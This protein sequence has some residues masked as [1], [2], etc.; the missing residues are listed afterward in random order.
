MFLWNNQ[1][2]EFL[3]FNKKKLDITKKKYFAENFLSALGGGEAVCE[4]FSN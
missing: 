3:V 2:N 1:R 4:T